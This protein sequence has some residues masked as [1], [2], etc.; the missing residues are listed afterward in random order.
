MGPAACQLSPLSACPSASV[1][2]EAA[3]LRKARKKVK[4]GMGGREGDERENK[5][6]GNE[7]KGAKNREEQ[8]RLA[9]KCNERAEG[10]RW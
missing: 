2:P 4:L 10:D 5:R 7:V 8:A 6:G 1:D 9:E 3:G